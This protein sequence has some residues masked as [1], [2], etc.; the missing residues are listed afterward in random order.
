MKTRKIKKLKKRPLSKSK[1]NKKFQK[2]L[3]RSTDLKLTTL[4]KIKTSLTIS[5]LQ[6]TGSFQES[7]QKVESQY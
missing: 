1:L 7:T 6:T 5:S 3:K 4:F 2:T